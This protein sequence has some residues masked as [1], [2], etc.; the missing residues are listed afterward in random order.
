MRSIQGSLPGGTF[1]IWRQFVVKPDAD[2]RA[3]GAW[4]GYIANDLG[5]VAYWYP[6]NPVQSTT[7]LDALKAWIDQQAAIE[8]FYIEDFDEEREK[9]V[10]RVYLVSASDVTE[11]RFLIDRDQGSLRYR[12]IV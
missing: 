9:A 11:K 6:S 10:V 4:V 8:A 1:T 2:D 5:T 3:N 12:E 7:T